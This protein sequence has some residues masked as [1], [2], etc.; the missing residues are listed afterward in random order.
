M[1]LANPFL[2]T[3]L[4]SLACSRPLVADEPAKKTGDKPVGIAKRV[5]WNT[6]EKSSARTLSIS[7]FSWTQ[8]VFPKLKFNEPLAMTWV[9]GSNRLLMVERRGKLF[10]FENSPAAEKPDLL[11]DT[12]KQTYGAAFHPQFQ[13]NGFIY[14]T[15]HVLD[16]KSIRCRREAASAPAGSA[17]DSRGS[18]R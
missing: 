11:L 17:R 18:L 2:I 5:P 14:V 16:D 13:A 7:P 4:I 3:V 10:T 15:Y 6:S 1:R 8:Q 9:P 12:G